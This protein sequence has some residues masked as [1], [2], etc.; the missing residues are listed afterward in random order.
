MSDQGK[1]LAAIR[2]EAKRKGWRVDR[3]KGYYK[4][5]CP[6]WCGRHMKTVKLTPSN[7]NYTRNLLG[8]LHR[9][10]CWDKKPPDEEAPQ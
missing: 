5:W 1:E 7:R 6:A 8:Q 3:G 10:T 4:M 9:A 2:E